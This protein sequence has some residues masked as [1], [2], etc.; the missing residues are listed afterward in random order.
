[1]AIE[2]NN[3]SQDNA[4]VES[5]SYNNVTINLRGADIRDVLSAI[6]VNM[7]KKIIYTAEQMNVDLSIDGV[8]SKTAMTYVLNTLG[9]DYIEDNNTLIIGKREELTKD[10]YNK[11]SLTKFVLKHVT[12]DV[13]S[14]QLDILSIPVQKIVL[15]SNKKVI[16]VQ[17]TP[18]DL[19]KVNELITMLDRAENM[20]EG[21]ADSSNLTPIKMKHISANKLN[22]ILGNIGL[23]LGIIIESNPMTLWVYGNKEEIDDIMNIQ[24]TFDIPENASSNDAIIS[25]VKLTYLTS[26]E[27]IEI[28]EELDLNIDIEV[29]H[30]GRSLKTAWLIGT[31]ESIKIAAD[32]IKKFDIEKLNSD[33]PFFIYETV[34]ITAN[35]LKNRFNNLNLSNIYM[36]TINYPEFSKSVMVFCPEDYRVFAMNHINKFDVMTEKIKVPIDYSGAPDGS[37]KLKKRRDL[38]VDLTGIPSD[39]FTISENVT[40]EDEKYHYVMYLEETQENIKLVK[41]YITYID[42]PLSDG[43]N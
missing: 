16:W 6:A 35:E 9:L 31:D 30:I 23:R 36:E 32:I 22:E 25:N 21:I 13:I 24:K 12:A 1:M 38:L 10:F 40:R 15:D 27:V 8:D 34:Y 17:G 5:T 42:F 37:N 14:E 3:I 33:N 39:S 2:D 19:S 4:S 41:D 20:S 7:D 29:V 26:N 28:F 11:L 18:Q 43:L